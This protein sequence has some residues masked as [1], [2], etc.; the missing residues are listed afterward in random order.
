MAKVAK[1]PCSIYTKNNCHKC[2]N[3]SSLFSMRDDG[4]QNPIIITA[5]GTTLAAIPI[6]TVCA[7]PTIHFFQLQAST[8]LLIIIT[9]ILHIIQ[10]SCM[11]LIQSSQ[12]KNDMVSWSKYYHEM[13]VMNSVQQIQVKQQRV[14][15]SPTL[16][17]HKFS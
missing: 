14:M 5:P 11:L 16:L 15:G 4:L 3:L 6:V 9:A 17:A 13:R 7:L 2:L 12:V 10:P 1:E 8:T